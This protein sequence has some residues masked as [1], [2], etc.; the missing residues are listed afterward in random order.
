LRTQA[1]PQ[2]K[3]T[4]AKPRAEHLQLLNR[5]VAWYHQTLLE[6]PK[7]KQALAA[8]GLTVPDLFHDFQVGFADNSVL[9]TI[10]EGSELQEGLKALGLL[11]EEGRE[12][13]QGCLVFPWFDENG[14]CL[15]VW[16]LEAASGKGK[17]LFGLSGVASCQAGHQ[18]RP[19]AKPEP[20]GVWNW[21]AAKR[22]RTVIVTDSILSAMRL[23]QAG[24]KEVIPAW[25]R[26]GLTSDHF[27]LFQ[28]YGTK[29]AHLTCEAK[30]VEEKLRE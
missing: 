10:P 4:A 9:K 25:G 20:A 14:N 5:T 6:D 2:P 3:E 19:K 8:L 26:D 21:Q 11:D 24:F 30:S 13:F 1:K 17:Y 22:S 27:R 12:T 18:Q 28:R 23:Y 16:G 29:D 15:G 7:G